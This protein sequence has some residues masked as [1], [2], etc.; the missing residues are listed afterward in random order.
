M[1]KN[2]NQFENKPLITVGQL[3]E[4]LNQFPSETPLDYG[5]IDIEQQAFDPWD[6]Y[7]GRKNG[8]SLSATVIKVKGGFSFSFLKA[9]NIQDRYSK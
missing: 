5:S 7:S 2:S 1:T 9:V 3:I 8:N 4:G 6:S